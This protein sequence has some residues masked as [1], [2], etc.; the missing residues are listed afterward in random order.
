[1]QVQQINSNLFWF[2]NKK[3]NVT[4]LQINLKILCIIF[5]TNIKLI[6]YKTILYITNIFNFFVL[7]PNR[8]PV[9]F[10]FFLNIL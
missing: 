5:I 6:K 3:K 2:N 10:F 9:R 4:I 1:M 8:V 7:E